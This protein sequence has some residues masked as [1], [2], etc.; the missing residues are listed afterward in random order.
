MARTRRTSVLLAVLP[1][2][3]ATIVATAGR[4]AAAETSRVTNLGPASLS[5]AIVTGVVN[6]DRGYV[7][8]RGVTPANLGVLDRTTGKV[9]TH[10]LPTSQGSWASAVSGGDV[11]VATY[12]PPV[13][14]R[15]AP[16]G[17]HTQL[18]APTTL[19][20]FFDLAAAPDGLLVAGGYP[21]GHTYTIDPQTGAVEDLG[22][23][24]PGEQ[25]VRSVAVDATTIYAGVGSHAHL[26]AIDRATKSTVDILPAE[27]RDDSFVYDIAVT[28]T[29]VVAAMVPSGRVAI[30]DKANPA[31]YRIVH[32]VPGL[33][34]GID[35][36]AVSGSG[37]TA[38]AYVSVRP[39][40]QLFRVDLGS[41]ATTDLGTPT[42]GEETR[43]LYVEG[44][45]LTGFSGSGITWS[46]PLPSGDFTVLD[47]QRAGFTAAPELALSVVTNGRAVLVGGNFGAQ[48]HNLGAGTSRR[49]RISGE[50]KTGVAAGNTAYVAVYPAGTVDSVNLDTG[51]VR[52]LTR[53]GHS[54]IR[55]RDMERADGLLFVG[56]QPDYGLLGGALSIVDERTGATDVYRNVV[57]DQS[58]LSV[59]TA[60]GVVYLGSEIYGGLGTNPKAKEAVLS[61]FDLA[62]RT[63]TRSLVPVPGATGITDVVVVGDTLVGVTNS[64]VMFEVDRATGQ[65]TRTTQLSTRGGQFQV[66]GSW[67]T[68]VD[69]DRVLRIDA[70]SWQVTTLATGLASSVAQGPLANDHDNLYTIAGT[71]L[72]RVAVR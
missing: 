25:Y 65:V 66:A 48:L 49:I 62:T 32:P 50:I 12:L 59:A 70:S 31:S 2:I 52:N 14:Y 21:N 9:T 45:T 67:M 54:Q 26:M 23:A 44:D 53:L 36:L 3:A 15:V 33:V 1:L 13:V 60:G 11:Y 34:G 57:P 17:S 47:L 56:T 5:A 58:I 18:A 35:A 8:S 24:Y 27:L 37:A 29:H 4:P 38:A 55:P 10:A 19:Q 42:P 71:N 68:F 61:F 63:V 43:N 64:G 6:G 51:A 28:D 7:V 41:G 69:A 22:Q 30:V 72:V 46:K 39:T 16:D 20:Y 40:G